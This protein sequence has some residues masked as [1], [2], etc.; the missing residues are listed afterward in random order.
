MQRAGSRLIFVAVED[1]LRAMERMSGI[2]AAR[3]ADWDE[4][5]GG[6]SR[7]GALLADFDAGFVGSA[8]KPLVVVTAFGVLGSRAHHP[9]P[10]ARAWN[11]AFDHSDVPER[12]KVVVHLQ[13]GLAVLDGLQ[14]LDMGKGASPEMIRLEFV[15]DDAVL[16]PPADLALIWPYAAEPGKLTLDNADGSTWWSRPGEAEREI[17][18]AAKALAKHIAQRRRR[19]ASKLVAPGPANERFVARFPYFATVDQARAI[20]GVLDDLA[21]GHP[22]DRVV[23]G[24]VGFG[25]TEVALRAAA[26]VALSGKQVAIAVPTTVL[27]RQHVTTF[28]KRFGLCGAW[29]RSPPGQKQ[30]P[31]RVRPFLSDRRCR[32]KS[33]SA[34]RLVRHSV[35]LRLSIIAR[36]HE[37]ASIPGELIPRA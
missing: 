35:P 19:R 7:E 17:Q 16:V 31:L 14:S 6:R 26:A 25:K 37:V 28:R 4:A 29:S 20:R 2:K 13:R 36:P 1:D 27:A 15:G 23:C 34:T 21:S 8:R 5:T 3:F 12:G 22:M 11:A 9:Q 18:A 30:S 32:S 33:V 24:D 10:A